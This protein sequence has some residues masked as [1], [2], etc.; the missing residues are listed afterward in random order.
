[1]EQILNG[2]N[3]LSLYY[4]K[5]L[6][7]DRY[8]LLLTTQYGRTTGMELN[9]IRFTSYSFLTSKRQEFSL[10]KSRQKVAILKFS[11]NDVI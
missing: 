10:K 6:L 2:R 7:S 11:L 3:F 4:A 1:M 9:N 5:N 8:M